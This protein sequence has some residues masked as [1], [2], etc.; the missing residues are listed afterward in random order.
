MTWYAQPNISGWAG[1]G[2]TI[3][4]Y[5]YDFFG[6]V[7]LLIIFSVFFI[8]SIKKGVATAF[9]TGT[10]WAMVG[11]TMLLIMSWAGPNAILLAM[12]LSGISLAIV[13]L[14]GMRDGI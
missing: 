1:F 10:L 3:N 9:L 4:S 2:T 7:T 14:G 6:P 11:G 5:T 8:A 12:I 13:V